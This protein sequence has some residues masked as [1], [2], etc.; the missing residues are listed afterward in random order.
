[1]LWRKE[2][3]IAK[4]FFRCGETIGAEHENSK[5]NIYNGTC[6]KKKE[7]D[8]SSFTEGQIHQLA[9]ALEA[10]G[11]TPKDVTMLGQYKKLDW[12]RGIFHETHKLVRTAKHIIDCDSAPY[13]PY[14]HWKLVKHRQSG[15]L[16]WDEERV[17]LHFSTTQKKGKSVAGCHILKEIKK[18]PLLNANVLDY[19]L[20]NQELIPEEW[21]KLKV[22]FWGTIYCEGSTPYA[23]YLN[24]SG[25]EWFWYYNRVDNVD[26]VSYK[27]P[28]VIL[29]K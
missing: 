13:M 24:W 29:L 22:Y 9:N 16:E 12:L 10:A 7:E 6:A 21:K 14:A 1:L 5:K 23:R 26:V 8:M 17:S 25:E 18:L 28:A 3:F 27:D 4:N 15:Q 11:F 2:F 20:K 19:L